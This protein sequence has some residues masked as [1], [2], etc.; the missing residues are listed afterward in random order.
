MIW[1]IKKLSID[2]TWHNK[3]TGGGK[4]ESNFNN[5]K[6]KIYWLLPPLI[7]SFFFNPVNKTWHGG[8][9]TKFIQIETLK[10]TTTKITASEENLNVVNLDGGFILYNSIPHD[11]YIMHS[12]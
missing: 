7:K 4:K 6:K 5:N 10:Q 2:P 12:V 1:N 8:G 3:Q 11:F 9:I